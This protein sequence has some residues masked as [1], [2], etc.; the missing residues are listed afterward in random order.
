V[1]D[2]TGIR[3]L[4]DFHLEFPPDETASGLFPASGLVRLRAAGSP[5]NIAP[6]VFA[7]RPQQLG[8]R[9]DAWQ[10]PREFLVIEHAEKPSED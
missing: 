9:L 6:A 10:G 7:A 2:W 1:I 3:G 5:G 4:F 8:L